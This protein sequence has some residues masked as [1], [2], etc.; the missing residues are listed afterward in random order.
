MLPAAFSRSRADLLHRVGATVVM[1]TDAHA[2]S[3]QEVAAAIAARPR[4]TVRC[5]IGPERVYDTIV[6]GHVKGEVGK[7]WSCQAVLSSDLFLAL[8]W[9][10]PFSDALLA[11]LITADEMAFLDN[12]LVTRP[13]NSQLYMTHDSTISILIFGTS[14]RSRPRNIKSHTKPYHFP[15]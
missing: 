11:N 2:E 7:Y 14:Q 8:P 1:E 13:F 5:C 9:C 3:I 15:E 6:K 10:Q 12:I 4:S